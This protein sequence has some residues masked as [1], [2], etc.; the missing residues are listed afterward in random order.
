VVTTGN[1]TGNAAFVQA[2]YLQFLHRAGDTSNLQDAGAWLDLIAKGTSTTE[3]ADR[4]ARSGEALQI[5]VEDLYRRFL[6]RDADAA[7]QAGWAGQLQQGLTL[8]SV[9]QQI[10]T[11]PEYQSLF[12]DDRAF[13]RSLYR[14]LLQRE[15]SPTE[16]AG[17]VSVV[18]SLGRDGVAQGFLT[19][20]ELRTDT[21]VED[22]AQLLHRLQPPSSAEVGGWLTDGFDALTMDVLFAA[23]S[24]F[25]SNG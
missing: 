9:T 8:E 20:L 4:L 14:G 22:Y 5:R 16:I 21:I 17:W 7:E 10:L 25:Q 24:E 23:S 1:L 11:S 15:G 6:G 12:V 19:S 13:V 3:V 18:P 2:L